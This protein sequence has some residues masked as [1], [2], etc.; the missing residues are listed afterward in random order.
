MRTQFTL[1]IVGAPFGLKGFVK[2]KPLSGETDHFLHL[3]K[4]LLRR[5]EKEETW[6]VAEISVQGEARDQVLLMRFGNIDNPE[7]AGLL[8]GAEIIAGREDAAP[9]KKDEYYV[10]DLKGLRVLTPEGNV[11]GTISAMAEGGGGDLA[12][13]LLLSGK[14][15]FVPFRNEFFGKVDL[16]GGAIVLLESWILDEELKD[17]AEN[18]SIDN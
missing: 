15:Q 16:E 6:E 1:G 4:V 3:K 5:E 11:L 18:R 7:D 12:E 8:K 2:V 10:E 14:K 9:L 13:I 17:T